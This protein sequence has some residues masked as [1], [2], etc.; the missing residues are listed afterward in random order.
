MLNPDMVY[1][2]AQEE[3]P[4]ETTDEEFG[5][6]FLD[7]AIDLQTPVEGIEAFGALRP[8]AWTVVQEAMIEGGQ[9]EEVFDP[10][11][12]STTGCSPTST[13]GIAPRSSRR[14]RPGPWRTCDL[15]H[16]ECRQCPAEVRRAPEEA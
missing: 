11:R 10:E 8:E 3:V 4:E 13:T 5:R 16:H 1:A 9:L 7:L 2:M 14:S 15:P 12:S 6:L